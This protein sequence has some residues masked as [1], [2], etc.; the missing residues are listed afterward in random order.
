MGLSRLKHRD[1][2][3]DWLRIASTKIR[4]QHK[5][6]ERR[7]LLLLKRCA[8]ELRGTAPSQSRPASSQSTD[9]AGPAT[10]VD[11]ARRH[12]TSP[13]RGRRVKW[14]DRR[15]RVKWSDHRAGLICRRQALYASDES[16]GNAGGIDET[17]TDISLRTDSV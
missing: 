16:V 15:R 14:R 2:Y 5:Q 7:F 13:R 11:S 9:D 12:C 4:N 8:P 17:T 1:Y 3:L 10:L 6:N